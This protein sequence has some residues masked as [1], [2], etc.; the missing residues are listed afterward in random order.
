MD[1]KPILIITE[2]HYAKQFEMLDQLMET[3]ARDIARDEQIAIEL[4]RVKSRRIFA[5]AVRNYKERTK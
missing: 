1:K 5:Q 3:I 4:A 2:E